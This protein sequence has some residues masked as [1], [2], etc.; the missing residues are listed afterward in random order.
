MGLVLV[1]ISSLATIAGKVAIV[2]APSFNDKLIPE[3]KPK[4]KKEPR[5]IRLTRSAGPTS[6]CRIPR[7]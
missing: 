4:K 5:I 2:A 1:Q 3:K 6:G 7:R